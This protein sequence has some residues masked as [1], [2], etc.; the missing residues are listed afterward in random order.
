VIGI[1]FRRNPF[2]H[3]GPS[4]QFKPAPII[5]K[6]NLPISWTRIKVFLPGNSEFEWRLGDQFGAERGRTMGAASG[7]EAEVAGTPA[8]VAASCCGR[9]G[10][11]EPSGRGGILVAIRPSGQAVPH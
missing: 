5:R 3:C 6:S 11:G 7:C 1:R 8:G 4:P 10:V 9:R 2:G